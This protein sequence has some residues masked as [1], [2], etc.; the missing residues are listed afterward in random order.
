MKN[1]LAPL[2][3]LDIQIEQD[4]VSFIE[5]SHASMEAI[6]LELGL[7]YVLEKKY[8]IAQVIFSTGCTPM[9]KYLEVRCKE[10]TMLPSFRD[11]FAPYFNN[12]LAVKAVQNSDLA[13][14]NIVPFI[15]PN[16]KR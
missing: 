15:R 12:L 10:K 1:A 16:T 6:R 2:E 5:S 14:A 13:K 8:D 3:K 11:I 9:S 7:L 4:I